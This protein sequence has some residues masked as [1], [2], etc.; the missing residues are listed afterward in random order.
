[1]SDSTEPRMSGADQVTERLGGQ[2]SLVTPEMRTFRVRL[3][4]KI[5]PNVV[6]VAQNKFINTSGSVR[7]HSRTGFHMPWTESRFVSLEDHHMDVKEETF[8]LKDTGFSVTSDCNITWRVKPIE[9][10]DLS[11]PTVGDKWR[12]FISRLGRNK[13]GAVV[14]GL[15]LGAAVVGAS[16]VATPIAGAAILAA[17]A[18]YISFGSPDQ[19][20]TKAQGA[21]NRVYNAPASMKALEDVILAE[22]RAY[23]ARHTYDEV[24]RQN[25]SLNHPEFV[26]LRAQL[27]AYTAKYGI[28]V[29]RFSIQSS[30]SPDSLR[31][32]QRQKDAE[33]KAK[34]QVLAAEAT[35]TETKLLATAEY[36]AEKLRIEA[37]RMQVQEL[38]KQG[39]TP[40]EIATLLEAQQYSQG[41]ANVNVVR[42][43]ATPVV[44]V[45]TPPKSK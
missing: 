35:A 3:F 9:D 31:V 27:D 25:V 22:L 20:W 43:N 38:I 26:S 45:S 32:L 18:G 33:V 39:F 15:V 29:T 24:Q 44:D 40:Q 14:K 42:G 41:G 1:M 28:E 11:K 23:Y 36:E 4:T 2:D 17:T 6:L 16:I 37:R 13:V 34:E 8:E 30:K 21:Y 7:I 19:E 5:P 10:D 12:G